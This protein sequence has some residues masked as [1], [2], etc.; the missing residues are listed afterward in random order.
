MRVLHV[1]PASDEAARE[2]CHVS[3][4]RGTAADW[5]NREFGMFE[6]AR[7]LQLPASQ[8]FRAQVHACDASDLECG[9]R[10]CLHDLR[11][12]AGLGYCHT[13]TRTHLCCCVASM[14]ACTCSTPACCS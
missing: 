2:L 12:G 8:P 14:S 11:L 1:T 10:G 7:C 5:V 13:V 4:T 6:H 9:L 3:Q